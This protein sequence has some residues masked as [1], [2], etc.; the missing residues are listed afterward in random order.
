M[1]ASLSVLVIS[2]NNED[3][4]KN[5]LESVKN[6]GEIIVVDSNSK[7][8]TLEIVHKVLESKVYKV[9]V[10]EFDDIGKQRSYGLKH[11]SGDWVLILDSDEVVSDK[12]KKEIL[13]L[14]QDDKQEFAAYEIPYQNYFLGKPLNYGGENYKMV[15][16]FQ[17]DSLEI[18]PSIVHNKLF[19]KKGRIGKLKCKILHYSYRSFGQVYRKFTDYAVKIAKI[20]ASKKEK[21]SLKKIFLYPVHMFW[22]RFIKDGGYKDGLFRIPLDLGFVYMEFLTYLLLFFYKK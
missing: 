18:K 7:D 13:K 3:T 4:I 12:L 15:R 16:L 20:K 8:K 19:V 2:K 5:T 6:L 11:L 22:A 21:S 10:K 17:R 14:V 1:K 9:L